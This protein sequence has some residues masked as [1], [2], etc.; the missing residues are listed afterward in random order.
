MRFSLIIPVYKVEKYIDKCVGSVL[1]QDFDDYEILLVDDGS[2]DNCGKICDDY[3]DKYA[4]IVSLHKENGGL[5]D[6][7]NY[8]LQYAQGEY[9]LFL[10]SDDWIAKGCLHVF[11]KVIGTEHPDVVETTLIE[12][13]ED[14]I[15]IKDKKFE[16]YLSQEF[17]KERAVKW[18]CCVSHNTWPAPKKIYSLT[19]LKK[20]NLQFLKGN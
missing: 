6:A 15:E 1:K 8:G 5:S 9:I 18:G 12:A 2:P 20:N 19:F 4:N 16:D 13:Y 7:R 14:K 3:A 11:D 10:D 17:T